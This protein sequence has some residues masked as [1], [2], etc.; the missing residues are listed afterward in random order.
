MEQLSWAAED[1]YLI[2]EVG[3]SVRATDETFFGLVRP[4]LASFAV[5]EP[6]EGYRRFSANVGEDRT[7]PGGK[8]T[9][10]INSL[11]LGM[12]RVYRGR[13]REEMAGRLLSL[14]RD[15]VTDGQNEFFRVRAGAVAVNGAAIILPSAPEPH[16]AGLVAIL[17]QRG[18]GYLADSMAKI[19]PV[20]RRSHGTALP[21]MVDEVDFPLLQGVDAPVPR[22][23]PRRDGGR[24]VVPPL[25]VSVE[26]LGGAWADPAPIGW[27]VL[28]SFDPGEETRLEPAGGADALFRF[29]EAVLNLHVWQDRAL[30]FTRDL[31]ESVPVSTLVVGSLPDA[32]DLLMRFAPSML[33]EVSV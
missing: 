9:R 22:A 11:Y 8:V 30:L 12:L 33:G 20:L 14:A 16:L 15:M 18:A 7:W 3:V 27:I 1:N 19:D 23:R 32:A 6:P 21:L 10:G 2:D 29:T 5:D 26:Q 25:P 31:L 28:V 13:Y 17:V 4:Y 24:G